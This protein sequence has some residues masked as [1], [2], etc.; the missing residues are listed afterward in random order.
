MG[1][2]VLWTLPSSRTQW[3][4]SSISRK[5]WRNFTSYQAIIF[6]RREKSVVK[7][8]VSSIK[9]HNLLS[10][11]KLFETIHKDFPRR[12]EHDCL[13]IHR[14]LYNEKNILHIDS[15]SNYCF[16]C[17]ILQGT[18]QGVQESYP[19][20]LFTLSAVRSAVTSNQ[21]SLV[22][23][24][25]SFISALAYAEVDDEFSS[26]ASLELSQESKQTFN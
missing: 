11:W 16:E 8:I 13:I 25:L 24:E 15:A 26:Q 3:H 6:K 5:I 22:K 7:W 21:N 23:C 10:R 1:D 2:S 9:I 4:K 14:Q 18:N 12:G 17:T 19:H 20:N